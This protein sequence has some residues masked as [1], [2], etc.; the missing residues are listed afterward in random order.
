MLNAPA[1]R[2]LRIP[3]RAL[4]M[5]ALTLL[6]VG[7]GD[8][9]VRSYQVPKSSPPGAVSGEMGHSHSEELHWHAPAGWQETPGSSLRLV[10]YRIP[11]GGPSAECYI[12][13]LA[14]DGGGEAA[15][16]N[17]W[18][19][20]LGLEPLDAATIAHEGK[21]GKAGAGAYRYFRIVNPDQPAKAMLA[22]ILPLGDRTAF[23]KLLAPA[24]KIDQLTPD[25]VAFCDS[26]AL[27]AAHS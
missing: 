8:E 10:N 5:T 15:N 16:V 23:V 20:Q 21:D 25:F 24:D 3:G 7:C 19:R 13:I 1:P 2:T 6:L 17:R 14:N 9:G 18:R 4:V 12:V 22:T 11:G 26:L 27:P